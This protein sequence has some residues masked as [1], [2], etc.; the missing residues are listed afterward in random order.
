MKPPST[1]PETLAYGYLESPIGALLVAGDDIGLHCIS[2]PRGSR[3]VGPGDVW[4]R[5]DAFF[6]EAFAQLSGYFRG[7]LTAF[8]L[9]LHFTGTAF[10]KTVWQALI[11]IPYGETTSYGA[12]ARAIGRPTASRA[13][14][15]ANGA[16]PLPIIAPCHRVIGADRSLTGFGGGLE[17]KRFLLD[18]ERRVAGSDGA[19][20]LLPL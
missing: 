10:Q 5:D 4:R 18:H 16:N 3:A 15:A 2:F 7:E 12:I 11:D 13:V 6:K 9:P 8:D 20:A 1:L 17:I 14:G 19:Q